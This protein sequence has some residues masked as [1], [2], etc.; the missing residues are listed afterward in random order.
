LIE[1]IRRHHAIVVKQYQV[2]AERLA[3]GPLA[4]IAQSEIGR[5]PL[6]VNANALARQSRL[7]A[8]E[9]LRSTVE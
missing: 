3:N 7:Q 1:P 8:G 2:I 5:R 6:D 9:K 4:G